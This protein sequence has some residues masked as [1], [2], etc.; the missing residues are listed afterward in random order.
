MASLFNQYSLFLILVAF[1]ALLAFLLF[2][3]GIR[4][5]EIIAF[6]VI[7]SGLAV[8]W[9]ALRPTQTPLSEA[10]SDV[11]A[12]IGVGRPVLLEFQSPY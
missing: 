5:Q 4:I 8:A 6:I 3:K 7:F 9:V 12:R 1:L 2:R 11:Q 10:A